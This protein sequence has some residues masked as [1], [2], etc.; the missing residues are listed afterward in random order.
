MDFVAQQRGSRV[1]CYATADVL[2]D[3]I[4]AM[5]VRVA[6]HWKEQTGNYPEQ[7]LLDGRVTTYEG[8]AQ[9]QTRRVVF[10]TDRLRG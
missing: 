7:V 6:D 1:M 3:D 10:I 9:L 5:A 2:R 4:D 8:L